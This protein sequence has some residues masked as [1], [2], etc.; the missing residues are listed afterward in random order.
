MK[1]QIFSLIELQN[2]TF[3]MDKLT[4]G[5]VDLPQEI[6]RLGEE[7]E[8]IER[9]LKEDEQRVEMLRADH[10]V[11]ETALKN[12]IENI[13]KAKSRLLEVKTNKEYEAILKEI[14][15]INEKN[16]AVEDEIIHLLEEIDRAGEDLKAKE[17]ET[18]GR[19][20]TCENE[21]RKM[22][23]ELNSIGSELK[24]VLK[25]S[26]E[27]RSRT[28]AGLLKKFDMIKDRKG[29]RAVVPVWKAVC[30][31]CHMN[32]PPQMY[33]ELQR[34]DK[35]M[36]CPHCERIIYWEDRNTDA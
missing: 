22:E 1:E 14:D 4:A 18:A 15:T 13:K 33:N 30:Y 6:N 17:S 23:K 34:N 36:L 21:I 3:E 31:G 28:K 11:K 27:T 19:R 10:K 24:K 29:G 2:I 25:R 7:L 5:R 26:D 32:I 9:E 20:S 12:S 35:L 16:G 8:S